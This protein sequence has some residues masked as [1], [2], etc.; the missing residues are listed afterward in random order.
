[1]G[2]Y[3]YVQILTWCNGLSTQQED[4]CYLREI[5]I[6]MGKYY[7]VQIMT[8]RNGRSH[9]PHAPHTA[10]GHY[11]LRRKFLLPGVTV[12]VTNLTDHSSDTIQLLPHK[13]ENLKSQCHSTSTTQK[14]AM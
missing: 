8:W 5:I 2:K 6:Y 1:M 13:K 7:H 14:V 4:I 3:Y 10:I 12:T 9:Q 11:Y